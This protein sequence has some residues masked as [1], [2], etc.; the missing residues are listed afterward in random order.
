[1]PWR[2]YCILL[3]LPM[4]AAGYY[5]SAGPASFAAASSTSASVLLP[6]STSS[7]LVATFPSSALSDASLFDVGASPLTC[8]PFWL[9]ATCDAGAGSVDVSAD[10]QVGRG[11]F[12]IAGKFTEVLRE[13]PGARGSLL[14]SVLGVDCGRGYDPF[15]KM[16][17]LEFVVVGGVTGFDGNGT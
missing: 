3:L 4:L 16:L 12:G 1:M 15:P 10:P 6:L 9:L 2:A 7:E 8:S 14:G 13:I 17:E 11:T 5:V